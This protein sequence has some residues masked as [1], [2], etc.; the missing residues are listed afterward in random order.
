MSNELLIQ[1]ELLFRQIHPACLHDDEPASDQF[2]PRP[3]ESGLLSVDRSSL[4]T[5]ANSHAL[6][7]ENGRKSGAVFGLTVG[8]F[9]GLGVHCVEDPLEAEGEIAANPAHALADFNRLDEKQRKI[10]SKRLKRAA[11]ARGRL[12]P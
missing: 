1:D 8:D 10:A 7:V 5:A 12:H 3:S 11:V 2:E 9:N 4:T 6:Y